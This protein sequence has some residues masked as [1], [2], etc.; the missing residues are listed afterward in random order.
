MVDKD[1]QGLR[2]EVPGMS[3]KAASK[4]NHEAQER[5]AKAGALRQAAFAELQVG[6]VQDATASLE[7]AAALEPEE[8]RSHSNL[9]VMAKVTGR[10]DEAER[11]YRQALKVSPEDPD[12]LYNL[13]N[14]YWS[15]GRKTEAASAYE[16]A[17]RVRP[18][19]AEALN[20]LGVVRIDAGDIMSAI[21][22]FQDALTAQPAYPSALSNLG[23]AYLLDGQPSLALR[24]YQEALSR[25]PG[26]RAL[27]LKRVQ[28]LL[29]LER[30]DEALDAC[31]EAI[32]AGLRDGELAIIAATILE[33][34]GQSALADEAFTQAAR[35]GLHSANGHYQM[36]L[37]LLRRDRGIESAASHLSQAVALEPD[38]FDA[39]LALSR[40]CSKLGQP[41]KAE[42]LIKRILALE[43]QHGFTA[44]RLDAVK[45]EAR[46]YR[47]ELKQ[48]G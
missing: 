14:L 1:K 32:D 15:Q 8:P 23:H 47:A 10:L 11:H 3:P 31:R 24:C 34:K 17:L 9:G 19:F 37:F 30:H 2:A 45:A 6:Y 36:G 18:R 22:L 7:K 43:S 33:H 26:D 39:M 44:R 46:A 42:I 4:T 21:T 27:R 5:E 13:G 20:S 12:A 41:D 16:R 28:A 40:A 48:A 38:H 35:I 29:L 25:S